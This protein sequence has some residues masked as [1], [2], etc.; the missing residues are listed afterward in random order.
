[1]ENF[2]SCTLTVYIFKTL[3]PL[4][5]KIIFRNTTIKIAKNQDNTSLAT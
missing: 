5:F 1:M 2:I 3:D 4:I